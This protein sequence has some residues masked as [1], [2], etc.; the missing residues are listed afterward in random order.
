MEI[1]E[2]AQDGT[3]R[4]VYA[5]IVKDRIVVLHA[6]KKKSHRAVATP[7]KDMDLIRQRLKEIAG[8]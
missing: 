5:T 8:S 1:C 2:R 6:F 7:K 3:Y 4:V